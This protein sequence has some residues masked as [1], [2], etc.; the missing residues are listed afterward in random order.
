[1]EDSEIQTKINIEKLKLNYEKNPE[2]RMK[3][4]KNIKK[5]NLQ[6]RK[7]SIIQQI[8]DLG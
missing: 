3:I 7:N 2:T 1:M 8:K 4:E 6:K 5:L